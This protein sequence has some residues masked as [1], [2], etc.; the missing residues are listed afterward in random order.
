MTRATLNSEPSKESDRDQNPY[1]GLWWPLR[2][3]ALNPLIWGMSF[4]MAMLFMVAV[5]SLLHI[6][7]F[8]YSVSGLDGDKII[9][10]LKEVGFIYAPN[11]LIAGLII[12][13]LMMG[14]SGKFIRSILDDY[15][16][17]I[18]V[19]NIFVSKQQRN[20]TLK[21]MHYSFAGIINRMN[22]SF[23]VALVAF[24]GYAVYDLYDKVVS[25][26]NSEVGLL[27]ENFY[28][29]IGD[30]SIIKHYNEN[31]DS[32][33]IA[34]MISTLKELDWSLKYAVDTAQ[35][36]VPNITYYQQLSF[37]IVCY[38][39]A[40]II[41]F[42]IIATPFFMMVFSVFEFVPKS[43][44][45]ST[46]KI[47]MSGFIDSSSDK[48]GLLVFKDTLLWAVTLSVLS[49]FSAYMAVTQNVY[50]DSCHDSYSSFLLDFTQIF[51]VHTFTSTTL[52]IYLII[53]VVLV[54][55]IICIALFVFIVDNQIK[56]ALDQELEGRN[57]SID[58]RIKEF[59]IWPYK[60]FKILHFIILIAILAV[61]IVA[62]RIGF[63]ILIVTFCVACYWLIQIGRDAVVGPKKGQSKMADGQNQRD[64]NASTTVHIETG[65]YVAG[66]KT[67]DSVAGN[68]WGG[69]NVAGDKVVMKIIDQ[70][71]HKAYHFDIF[72]AHREL[73]HILQE[74]NANKNASGD[75]HRIHL[76]QQALRAAEK[77]DRKTL[78]SQ[79]QSAKEWCL[80]FAKNV[81]ANVVAGIIN[82]HLT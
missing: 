56:S 49:Y 77:G 40:P 6:G 29:P 34:K 79:L 53:L 2:S 58:V 64:G 48:F 66:N 75:D 19:Q 9:N 43:S 37:D 44:A 68:K 67:G 4:F 52:K 24:G 23:I 10:I 74:L 78:V 45:L 38:V 50:L 17:M 41:G 18:M 81:G 11:W 31:L 54:S 13:P 59:T 12:M 25:V 73:G 76:I 8:E 62:Y 21:E 57:Q 69:D 61:S 7:E 5:S 1:A 36:I 51:K 70:S 80:D 47:S 27:K 39:I 35:G 32:T 20:L 15:Y 46:N 16:N 22:W 63:Y 71:V 14:L 3:L 65:D 28:C 42:S 60:N 72:V 82:G 30:H 33:Q 26:L 55:K